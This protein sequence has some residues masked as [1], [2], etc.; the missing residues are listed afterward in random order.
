MAYL[1]FRAA[2]LLGYDDLL[3]A[4]QRIINVG[5]QRA[6]V[7]AD[8]GLARGFADPWKRLTDAWI[9]ENRRSWD[10]PLSVKAGS[11]GVANRWG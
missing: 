11:A 10:H 5:K 4:M 8:R 1:H 6:V 2:R 7:E 9:L 3:L